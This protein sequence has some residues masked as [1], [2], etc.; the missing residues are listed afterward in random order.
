MKECKVEVGFGAQAM[1]LTTF[2]SSDPAYKHI[3]IRTFLVETVLER[4]VSCPT[5]YFSL[6]WSMLNIKLAIQRVRRFLLAFHTFYFI[7]TIKSSPITQ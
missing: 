7:A 5:F 4:I 1:Q 3:R 6:F 2:A